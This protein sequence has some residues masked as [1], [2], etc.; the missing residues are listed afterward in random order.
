MASEARDF[1]YYNGKPVLISGQQWLFVM[2]AI[3]CGYAVLV[4][5]ANVP[6]FTTRF[7]QFI[8][9]ILFFAFPLAA[10]AAVTPQHWT[11]L[12]RKIRVRDVMWMILF[13][14]LNI[15]V[16]MAVGLAVWALTTTAANP[17]IGAVGSMASD[18]LTFFFLKTIP[19][20]FGEEVL[21]IL[22]F[23]ALTYVLHTRM[24]MSRTVAILGAWLIAAMLFGAAHLPTYNWNWAQCFIVIGGA[25]LVL[26]LPYMLTKNIWVSAGAH[27]L[28]DWALLGFTLAGPYL[29]KAA[30][31][32]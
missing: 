23:L 8:P 32:S 11:A 17:V 5:A 30:A 18:D 25:R 22:P 26:L 2:A 14:L 16:T 31:A 19:Q 28:N 1:P 21:A 4:L 24:Q 9:A 20:L 6:F 7:G 27:I 15:I 10:L 13:A 3:V 12:F 29:L